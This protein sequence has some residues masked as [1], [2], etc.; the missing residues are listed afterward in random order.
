MS[1]TQGYE[2][3]LRIGSDAVAETTTWDLTITNPTFDRVVFQSGGWRESVVTGGRNWN[4]TA[5]GFLDLSDAQQLA[6]H[7]AAV[8]G[9]T[10]STVRFYVD[11]DAG[12][13]WTPDTDTDADATAIIESFNSNNDASG[14]ATYSIAL[15]GSGP[16]KYVSA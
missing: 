8:S 7:D 6:F 12:T 15:K 13:Y 4:A 5:D 16:I 14:Q 3:D 11:Y 1:I 10:I 2:G 9:T